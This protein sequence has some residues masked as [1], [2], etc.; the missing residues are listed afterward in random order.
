MFRRWRMPKMTQAGSMIMRTKVNSGLIVSKM[1]SAPMMVMEQ[2]RMF[3]GP[4]WASSTISNRSLVTRASSTPVLF[5]S[6]KLYDSDC[7]CVN[8]SLRMSAST[9]VPIRC[10]IT[11]TK[12]WHTARSI[13]A[14]NIIAITMKNVRNIPSGSRLRIDHL[15]TYG[16]IRSTT[17]IPTDSAI[18]MA[19]AFLWGTI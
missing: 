2:V 17:A 14:A 11:V 16:K 8:T 10:P 1:T 19:K 4:W 3:S 15:D 6:K 9:R 5:L 18:S 12:Y 7:I 13:Y